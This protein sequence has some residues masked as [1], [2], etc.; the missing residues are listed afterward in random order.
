M[1]VYACLLYYSV[2]IKQGSQSRTSLAK[3]ETPSSK[4]T[5]AKRYGGIEYLTSKCKALSSNPST[6]KK[7]RQRKQ[8]YTDKNNKEFAISSFSIYG[9]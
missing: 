5:R 7:R 2:N 3:S 4:I 6:A 9:S 1:E 8:R